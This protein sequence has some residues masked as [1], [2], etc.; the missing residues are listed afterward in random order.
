MYINIKIFTLYYF[1]SIVSVSLFKIYFRHQ[2]NF[3]AISKPLYGISQ[4]TT[5]SY[6]I[7]TG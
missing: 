6:T 1:I 3:Q 5:F 4:Q 7:S 2:S